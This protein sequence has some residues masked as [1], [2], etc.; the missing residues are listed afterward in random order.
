M[1]R[2]QGFT[3]IELLIVISIVGFIAAFSIP[4]FGNFIQDYRVFSETNQLVN[5]LSLAKSEAIKRSTEV[6]LEFTRNTNA[7]S[8]NDWRYNWSIYL[9][10]NSNNTLDTGESIIKEGRGDLELSIAG[11]LTTNAGNFR[12]NAKGLITA[13]NIPQDTN[14]NFILRVCDKRRDGTAFELNRIGRAEKTKHSSKNSPANPIPANQ[15]NYR[16]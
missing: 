7:G 14:G 13:S 2:T 10:A 15:C 6:S 5:S 11:N 12:F 9:D 16:L 1:Q 4:W 3:L 8:L